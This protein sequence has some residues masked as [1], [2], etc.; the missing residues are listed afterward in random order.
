MG[1][2][3]VKNNDRRNTCQNKPDV[4]IGTWLAFLVSCRYAIV[5][6]EWHTAMIDLYNSLSA[7]QVSSGG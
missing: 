3:N 2:P 6:A 1:I 5:F 7:K 4:I